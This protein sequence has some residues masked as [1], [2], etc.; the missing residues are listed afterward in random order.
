MSLKGNIKMDLK[1]VRNNVVVLKFRAQD[2]EFVTCLCE[3]RNESK[4][5]A[6]FLTR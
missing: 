2:I 5:M 3:R 4:N 6:N 1:Q